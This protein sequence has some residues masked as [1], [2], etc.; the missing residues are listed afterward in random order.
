MKKIAEFFRNDHIQGSLVCGIC[1]I[2]LALFFK[3][4]MHMEEVPYL[5]NAAPGF[6]FTIWETYRKKIKSPF[7][8]RV[9]PWNIIQL[10]V[11]AIIMARYL[12]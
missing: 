1:I 4:I 6:V 9:L 11:T 10:L 7:W 12:I 5:E 2:G 3:P 8:K